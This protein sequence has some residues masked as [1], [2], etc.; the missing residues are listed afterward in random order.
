MRKLLFLTIVPLC[1]AV[2]PAGALTPDEILAASR[3]PAQVTTSVARAEVAIS[4]VDGSTLHR[5]VDIYTAR[6]QAGLKRLVR[7]EAP[8]RVKGQ[9][10]LASNSLIELR[11][12]M[13]E[14]RSVS[15]AEASAGFL[16]SSFSM[17]DLQPRDASLDMNAIVRE[18]NAAGRDCYVIESAPKAPEAYSKVIR[19]ISKDGLLLVKAEMYDSRGGLSKRLEA[20][21]F[22]TVQGQPVARVLTMEDR[23]TITTTQ[24]RFTELSYDA[25]LPAGVF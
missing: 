25:D 5:S 24:V 15:A 23:R 3:F 6:D 4:L 18:E 2:L 12:P 1:V 19:W 21:G 22:E 9:S 8:A 11:S 7:A 13:E 10:L 16:G 17:A 14:P 20:S